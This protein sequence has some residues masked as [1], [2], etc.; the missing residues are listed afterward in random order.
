MRTKS[1]PIKRKPPADFKEVKRRFIRQ[2]RELAKNNSGQSLR[3]RSLELEVSRLLADN[4][5]LRNQVLHLQNEVSSAQKKAST[6]AARRVKDEMRAK[7]VALSRI[8]DGIDDAEEV[9]RP[10]GEKKPVEGNWRE[11]QTLTELMR[12]TAL[13]TISEDKLYPRRT[14]GADEIQPIRLSDQSSNESPDLG[15]PPV[16]HFDYEDPIKTAS[17]LNGKVSPPKLDAAADEEVLPASLTV[18]LETRRK[19]KDGP[20]RLEIRRHSLLAEAPAKPEGEQASILRAG[21]KRKLADREGEKPSKPPS[22]GDFTFSR[23]SSGEQ[24]KKS[25]NAK[26]TNAEQGDTIVVASPAP[27]R[28][29]LGD[30]SVNMSPRKA[31]ASDAKPDKN[32][33]EKPISSRLTASR[34]TTTTS[35]RRTSSIPIPSP[36]RDS[37]QTVDLP[38]ST[39]STDPTTPAAFDLFSPPTTT[40]TSSPSAAKPSGR[41]DTPPPSDMSSLSLTTSDASRQPRRA[42]SAVNYAEPSLIAKMRRPDKKMVDALT[43][44]QDHRRAMS[45]S[46][47]RKLSPGPVT[48]KKEAPEDEGEGEWKNLPNARNVSPL[49][50]KSSSTESLNQ[51]YAD[52]PTVP[53]TRPSSSA[54]TISALM[55]GSRRRRQ[56]VQ[57]ES[58]PLGTDM[59]IE[60]AA[61]KLEDLDLYEFKESSSPR[62]DGSSSGGVGDVKAGRTMAGRTHRRHSSVPKN[63]RVGSEGALGS[64]GS[65]RTTGTTGA[66]FSDSKPG[67]VAAKAERVAS[68]RR[69]MML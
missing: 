17:P 11:R 38:T 66:A 13:P 64:A 42:R 27:A 34:D 45:A 43:G 32:K 24:A 41:G 2:N 30:K 69:S 52:L 65:A 10:R 44:L 7:I 4:L 1:A 35:R 58:E 56:S 21:A 63:A 59:D 19:R 57:V 49:L 20:S 37:V 33:S 16:A 28:K 9:E 15:P 55:A 31:A 29:V 53:A 60:A 48:V 5:E 8:V 39:L 26:P 25:E 51:Q 54:A 68:R 47:E 6:S 22:K 14:L 18:N 62:T 3:I 12:D 23:K 61:K 67:A 50:K 36:P 40:T 46:G